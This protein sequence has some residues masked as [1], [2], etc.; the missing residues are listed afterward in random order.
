MT[1]QP[2]TIGDTT[3]T[4]VGN[5]PTL[6]FCH[7]FT[8]TS[9]FWREQI[10]AFS[11][12]YRMILI[13]LPGHGKSPAPTM[14]DYSMDSYTADLE[15][16]FAA[17]QVRDAVLIGLSMGGTIAQ[18]F[19]AT[20]AARLKGLVLVGATSHGLGPAVQAGAVLKNIESLGVE[21]ASQQV[22]EKSF[23]AGA[24]RELIDFARAEVVQT[25]VGV[26]RAAITSLNRADS[27]RLLHTLRMPTLVVCGVDDAITPPNESVALS[28]AIPNAELCLIAGAGHFPMLEKPQQFN[29][30]LADFLGS[31]P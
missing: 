2:F 12:R 31:I 29:E 5:G 25:P 8:T 11:N 27:R 30:A 3:G 22:I 23:G 1:P 15:L 17:L 4:I 9:Q 6:V 20:N 14:R 24:S 26:A 21:A 18:Q 7:G 13:D 10:P 19:A 28:A 16:I